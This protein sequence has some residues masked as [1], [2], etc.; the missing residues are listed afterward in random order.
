MFR[1][2]CAA[3]LPANGLIN[4]LGD[5][6]KIAMQLAES[7]RKRM[8]FFFKSTLMGGTPSPEPH[9]IYRF[10]PVWMRTPRKPYNQVACRRIGQRRDA[11]RAPIQARCGW[12]PLAASPS[13]PTNTRGALPTQNS[14][15]APISTAGLASPPQTRA[16]WREAQLIQPGKGCA[17]RSLSAGRVLL[18]SAKARRVDQP[19]TRL[20]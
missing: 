16:P 7:K 14:V 9:G 15:E 11:P 6:P 2:V 5:W 18:N 12:R 3:I 1:E 19:A 17:G 8:R 20:R 13:K 10:P 4:T